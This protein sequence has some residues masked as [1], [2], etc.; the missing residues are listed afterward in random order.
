MAIVVSNMLL[1]YLK[2]AKLA[3]K[4]TFAGKGLSEVI[5]RWALD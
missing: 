5:M 3:R 1:S 2:L 4:K